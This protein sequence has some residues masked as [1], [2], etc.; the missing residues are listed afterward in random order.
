MGK[1]VSC[2]PIM[3]IRSTAIRFLDNDTRKKRFSNGGQGSIHEIDTHKRRQARPRFHE[4]LFG[5]PVPSSSPTTTANW[6][7]AMLTTLQG[8]TKHCAGD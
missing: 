3:L 5:E 8:I 1:T 7:L 4:T 2:Q 6:N